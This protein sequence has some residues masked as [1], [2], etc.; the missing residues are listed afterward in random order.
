L[1]EALLLGGAGALLGVLIAYWGG[2]AFVALGPA[3]IPLLADARIDGIVLGFTVIVTLL[4]VGLAGL[5]PALRLGRTR[6]TE[7]L[8]QSA[9]RVQSRED[10]RVIRSLSVAQIAL[11]MVL[12]TTGGL[13]VRSFQAL[14]TVNPGLDPER[15]LTFQLELPM[16]AGTTYPSQEGRDAFFAALLEQIAAVPGVDAVTMASAPPLEEEPSLYTFTLPGTAD[17]RELRGTVRL[18]APGYFRLLGIPVLQGRS[19]DDADRRQGL[20][21]V[22]VSAALARAAW[23][24]ASPH[25][26]ADRDGIRRRS[27]G[28]RGG[29]G[30]A[31]RWA[32][33]RGGP[34]RLRAGLTAEL[35]LH[36]AAG[37]DS[38]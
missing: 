38:R 31:G 35:Q 30:R 19:F 22:L 26:A 28:G 7:T 27:R 15:V 2:R 4:T 36:D 5:V 11:A 13:L 29:R 23:G 33:Y 34:H 8:G 32:R 9:T 3:D 16:G 12:V 25:R 21:V 20:R 37:E 24:S 14:L 17:A 6:L 10:H 1:S 18:V